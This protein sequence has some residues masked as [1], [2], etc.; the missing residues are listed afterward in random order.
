M[1]GVTSGC[2]RQWGSKSSRIVPFEGGSGTM[3]SPLTAGSHMMRFIVL[4]PG[5]RGTHFAHRQA[6]AGSPVTR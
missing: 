4:Q 5:S 1:G 3:R 2:P 6:P